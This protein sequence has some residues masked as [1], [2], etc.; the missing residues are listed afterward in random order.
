MA[1]VDSKGRDC[2]FKAGVYLL[3]ELALVIAM[4]AAIGADP[5]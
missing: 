3:A 1:N 2:G 5:D 4:A